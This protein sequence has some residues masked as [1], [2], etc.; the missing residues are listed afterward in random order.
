M[1]A[2]VTDHSPDPTAL[3]MLGVWTVAL[4]ALAVLAYRLDQGRR[5]R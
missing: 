2:A 4:G 1:W 5:F 3:L